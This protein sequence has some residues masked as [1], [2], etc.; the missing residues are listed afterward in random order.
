MRSG[1][2]RI[3]SCIS[4]SMPSRMGPVHFDYPAPT[5][6]RNSWPV[7][8]MSRVVELIRQLGHAT[9]ERVW[10]LGFAA[11]FLWVVLLYSGASF[12]RRH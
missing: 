3:L 6:V 4:S 5:D 11:R 10:R 2:R 7:G 8:R 1:P 9:V 12:R